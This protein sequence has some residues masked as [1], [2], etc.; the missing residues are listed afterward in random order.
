ML[1]NAA[2]PPPS[3]GLGRSDLAGA[4]DRVAVFSKRRGLRRRR[5]RLRRR[6]LGRPAGPPRPA[7]RPAGDR[8]PRPARARRAAG[9]ADRRRRPV[10]RPPPRGP[11]HGRRAA[12]LRRGRRRGGR[13]TGSSPCVAP[14]PTSSSWP[15]TSDWLASIV[16]HVTRKRTQA[17]NA[18]VLAAMIAVEFL[19]PERLWW[20]LAVAALGVAYVA[21]QRWRRRAQVRFTQV[22]LLDRVAPSRPGLAPARRRRHPAARPHRRRH[23]HRPSGLDDERAHGERRT[24]PRAVRRVAVDDGHRRRSDP[25]RGGQGGGARLRRP[26]RRR[27]RGRP[28]L[29]QRQR[30][31]RGRPDARPRG[32]W[33][34]ASRTCSWPS[35]RPSA[36][37][38]PPAR[39]C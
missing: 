7:P 32:A 4:I 26:G 17:V 9:R 28:D 36:T 1:S 34:T 22:D 16:G 18:Q 13:P 5:L 8:R 27:R 12:A 11:R 37:R 3:E 2:T 29:L 24:H 20:L 14:A 15:P 21:V 10:D 39:P 25:A 6:Q 33:T 23:R 35:R 19:N 31:R 30:R 38:S